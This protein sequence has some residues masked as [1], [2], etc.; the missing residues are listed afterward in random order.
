MRCIH[1]VV[2]RRPAWKKLRFILSDRSDIHMTDNILIAIHAFASHVLMSFSVDETLLLRSM[3]LSSNFREPPFSVEVSSFWFW[4]KHFAFCFVC[5]DMEACS[6]CCLL[7]TMQR[8]F[9]QRRCICQKR[10]VISVVC[11]HSS[12]CGVSSASCLCQCKAICFH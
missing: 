8:G 2:W 11:A 7:K 6:T 5:I 1:I 12:L 10:Y 9:G 4:L 3:N